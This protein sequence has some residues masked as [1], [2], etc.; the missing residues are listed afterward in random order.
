MQGTRSRAADAVCPKSG[1]RVTSRIAIGLPY[2]ADHAVQAETECVKQ[3]LVFWQNSDEY[4][5]TRVRSA[6]RL[7]LEQLP[8]GSSRWLKVRGPMAVMCV[9]FDAG[10]FPLHPTNWK[11]AGGEGVYWSFTGVGDSAEL[12]QVLS[13]DILSVHR[14]LAATHWDGAGLEKGCDVSIIKQHLRFFEKR[15]N[16]A[17]YG[18]LLTAAMGACWQKARVAGCATSSWMNARRHPQMPALLPAR[19]A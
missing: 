13:R 16:H 2:N 8:D 17:M 11:Q 5:R 18:A 6:W 12:I 10:W 14:A 1:R 7:S 4:V 3:W 15:E 9:L 19:Q